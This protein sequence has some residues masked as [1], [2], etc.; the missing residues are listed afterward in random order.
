MENYVMALKKQE[1]LLLDNI[2]QTANIVKGL[3][4]NDLVKINEQIS[5]LLA[6]FAEETKSKVVLGI[7]EDGEIT[8]TVIDL[9]SDYVRT[10]HNTEKT[11]LSL[12]GK[13]NGVPMDIKVVKDETS[14]TNKEVA[15]A[16]AEL[17]LIV[18]N[19]P[20]EMKEHGH[21]DWLRD[22]GAYPKGAVEPEGDSDEDL[23]EEFLAD[24]ADDAD[25]NDL[26]AKESESG[27]EYNEESHTQA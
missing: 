21:D 3:V 27:E 4:G 11:M 17:S 10:R 2:L 24:D 14:F 20:V 26:G 1:Q 9:K 18:A 15:D 12:K 23:S 13:L 16:L 22:V 19:M 7:T 6:G 8:S 5:V 25:E